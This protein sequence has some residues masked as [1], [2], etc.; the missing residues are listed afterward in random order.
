MC[1]R[2]LPIL[3]LQHIRERALQHPRRSAAEAH[4]MLTQ[5]GAAPTGLHA[6]KAHLAVRNELIEGANGVRPAAYA[7]NH[8]R[9]QPA[10][11]LENLLLHLAAD[12]AMEI[13]HHGW[14]R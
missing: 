8:S 14:V 11:L 6:N 2:N 4:R 13:P 5:L 1:K 3:I 9:R 10:F 12:A 7:G